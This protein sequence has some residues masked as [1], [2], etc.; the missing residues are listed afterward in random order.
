MLSFVNYVT[1]PPDDWALGIAEAFSSRRVPSFQRPPRFRVFEADG[2]R[3]DQR[4]R[5]Q[6][7]TSP[8][9]M[10][11]NPEAPCVNAASTPD[12]ATRLTASRLGSNPLRRHRQ[13]N[14]SSSYQS[15]SRVTLAVLRVMFRNAVATPYLALLDHAQHRRRVGSIEYT[16]MPSP[17]SAIASATTIQG[18]VSVRQPCPGRISDSDKHPKSRELDSSARPKR[19]ASCPR[20]RPDEREPHRGGRDVQPGHSR[21]DRSSTSWR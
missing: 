5:Y 19:S 9:A 13:G 14:D 6:D 8:S 10:N 17:C 21:A 12:A 4:D 18:A 11:A 15:N 2:L 3:R 7:E 20:Q 16:P 1:T